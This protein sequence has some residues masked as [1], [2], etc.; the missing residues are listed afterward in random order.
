MSPKRVA[1]IAVIAAIV[2]AGF[3]G[4][5]LNNFELPEMNAYAWGLVALAA[6][7]QITASWFYGLLYK[8]S[9]EEA[10][11][12]L[13]GILGIQGGLGRCG[14]GPAHSGRWGHHPGGDGLDGPR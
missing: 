3:A 2:Y 12:E 8:E 9:V 5:I 14:C 13:Q 10:G 1:W 6:I 7:A 11:G 4:F